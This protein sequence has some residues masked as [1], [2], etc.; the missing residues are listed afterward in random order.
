MSEFQHPYGKVP[1]CELIGG[2]EIYNDPGLG[3]IWT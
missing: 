1:V 2:I 3:L